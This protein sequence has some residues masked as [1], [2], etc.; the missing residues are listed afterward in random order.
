MVPGLL[1]ALA[2]SGDTLAQKE[3][4]FENGGLYLTP[5]QGLGAMA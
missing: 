4:G 5:V 1:A 3:P 2:I